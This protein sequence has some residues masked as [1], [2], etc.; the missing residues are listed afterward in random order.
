[1]VEADQHAWTLEELQ[2]GLAGR[3]VTADFSSVFRAVTRLEE[4]GVVRRV[5]L[6]EGRTRFELAGAHHDHLRC[7]RCGDLRPAPCGVLE[8]SLA[9]LQAVTGFAITGHRLTVNGLCPSCQRTGTGEPLAPE[10]TAPEP[11]GPARVRQT[12]EPR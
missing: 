9:D 7:D 2:A 12:T 10:L 6:D 8:A 1:M 11:A 3:A 4:T 5:E